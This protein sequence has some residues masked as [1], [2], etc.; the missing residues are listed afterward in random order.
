[1]TAEVAIL[2][3]RAVALAADSAVTISY[4]GREKIY[5]SANKLFMLSRYQPVGIMFYGAAEFMDI[6][7]ETIVKVYRD[8]IG[9]GKFDTLEEYAQDFLVFLAATDNGLYSEEEQGRYFERFVF[10]LRL[11]VL[12]VVVSQGLDPENDKGKLEAAV[13][14]AI[15]DIHGGW[16]DAPDMP[17]LPDEYGSKVLDRY[18]SL[19]EDSIER[20]FSDIPLS[21]E[22]RELLI[23]T[24]VFLVTKGRFPDNCAGVVIAG[25]GE[26][27]VFPSLVCYDL[28]A[29]ILNRLKYQKLEG[30]SVR[31]GFS[32]DTATAAVVPF[33]Q[34]EV[35]TTFIEGISPD[36]EQLLLSYLRKLFDLY[37]EILLDGIP[38]VE[39]DH[40]SALAE[41]L[42]KAGAKLVEVFAKDMRQGRRDRYINPIIENVSNLPLEELALMAETLVNI[43][44]FKRR[45]SIGSETV[46]EPIDVAVISKKDGFI[47]IKRKHYF[48][49]QY[50][51]HF[52]ANYFR[53]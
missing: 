10:L 41:E 33:A 49:R 26:K 19:I 38:Q 8:K 12:S 13:D 43:T 46:G 52:F 34:D 15:K 18:R 1:M 20:H 44:A 17:S 16:D 36:Y 48:E 7:W 14:D 51:Q 28:E 11:W 29:V 53:E 39:D 50:N 9:S 31:V 21:D 42:K 47:W 22:S 3:T 40:K 6:P 25:F 23:E 4:P 30:K 37:P 2:N 27:E 35:V 24:C 45:V 32:L 5:F